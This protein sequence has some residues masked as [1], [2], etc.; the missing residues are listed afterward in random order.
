MGWEDNS[1]DWNVPDTS[2]YPSGDG[3]DFTN[4]YDAGQFDPSSFQ[5]DMPSFDWNDS[6]IL[7]SLGISSYDVPTPESLMFQSQSPMGLA[8]QLAIEQYQSQIPPDVASILTAKG[9]DP[10]T[11]RISENGYISTP[12][13]EFTPEELQ[14][15][16]VGGVKSEDEQLAPIS[17]DSQPSASNI[18]SSGIYGDMKL[19]EGEVV[20]PLWKQSAT[21]Q[22]LIDN[23]SARDDLSTPEKIKMLQDMKLLG[24]FVEPD[25]Y[26]KESAVASPDEYRADNRSVGQKLLQGALNMMKPGTN[27]AKTYRR[28]AD[29]S[30]T[31]T[32]ARE[33]SILEKALQ[34][35]GILAGGG[36]KAPDAIGDR[37][38]QAWSVGRKAGSGRKMATGGAVGGSGTK[39]GALGLLQGASTGQSDKVDAKLSHGEYVVDADV[40][41]ALGDGNT[42]AGADK[43]DQMRQAVRSHKRSAPSG[44]IPPAAKSPLQYM[45]GAA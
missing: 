27:G 24:G 11:S 26:N 25:A 22:G 21:E 18:Y 1:Y 43:L 33:S 31:E 37:G 16:N 32:Q 4:Y 28:N 8:D 35:Y 13:G 36:G 38:A 20:N 17:I 15:M 7:S 30:V 2:Y 41:S 5:L 23:I 12:R 6:D 14:S 42:E 29:G 9:I 45:K 19:P 34:A 3:L 44:K 39:K 40:V 10:A